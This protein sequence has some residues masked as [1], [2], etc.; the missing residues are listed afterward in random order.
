MRA[1]NQIISEGPFEVVDNATCLANIKGEDKLYKYV[2]INKAY[3]MCTRGQSQIFCRDDV[4]PGPLTCK[5]GDKWVLQG[6]NAWSKASCAMNGYSVFL[7]ASSVSDYLSIDVPDF[8]SK[9]VFG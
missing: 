7:R 2:F 5:Q 6:I 8:M 3:S 9:Y 1:T 4:V